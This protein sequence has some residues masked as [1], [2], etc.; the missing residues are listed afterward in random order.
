[1]KNIMPHRLAS[2]VHMILLVVVTAAAPGYGQGDPGGKRNL[3]IDSPLPRGA[4]LA[5]GHP[6]DVGI[7]SHAAVIF[8]DNFEA[9]EYPEKWDSVRDKDEQVLDLIDHVVGSRSNVGKLRHGSV[10][11][12][13][14]QR[15]VL[16]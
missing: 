11:Q 4:G 10:D 15:G 14:N 16:R 13:P 7:G 2:H 6:G 8:C 12:E 3:A 9:G 5:E 1:M